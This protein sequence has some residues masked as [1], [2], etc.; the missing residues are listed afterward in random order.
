MY[1]IENI[2]HSNSSVVASLCWA[3]CLY[4]AVVCNVI[5]KQRLP[6]NCLL[7]GRCLALSRLEVK[8]GSINHFR[9]QEPDLRPSSRHSFGHIVKKMD[10]MSGWQCKLALSKR[11]PR[12]SPALCCRQLLLPP[13]RRPYINL[14]TLVRSD[15]HSWPALDI[16]SDV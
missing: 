5:T 16:P 1:V 4:N 9:I 11:Q 6:Y 14:L 7:S 3:E 10:A 8:F 2:H 12:A 13:P 15:R